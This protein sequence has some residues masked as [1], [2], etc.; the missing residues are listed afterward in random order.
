VKNIANMI[1]GRIHAINHAHSNDCPAGS[2]TE[3]ES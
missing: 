3:F 2:V 1:L